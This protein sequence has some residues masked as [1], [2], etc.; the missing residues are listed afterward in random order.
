MLFLPY[1]KDF[2]HITFTEVRTERHQTKTALQFTFVLITIQ[3]MREY[4]KV[5]QLLTFKRLCQKNMNQRTQE[6]IL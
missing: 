3:A 4:I 2:I 5:K 1:H 6:K